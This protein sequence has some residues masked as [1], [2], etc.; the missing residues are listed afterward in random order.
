LSTEDE[1]EQRQH[2]GRPGDDQ[3]RADDQRHPP[4]EVDDQ[5]GRQGDA[6]EGD[7]GADADQLPDHLAGRPLE[8]GEVEPQPGL[9][10]DQPDAERDEGLEGGAEQGFGVDVVGQYPGDEADRQ[11][12][13]QRRDPQ[14]LGD[15]A[16]G[17]GEDDDQAEAG[18]DV[19]G[20]EHGAGQEDGH[21]AR[22]PSR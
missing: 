5:P 9:E 1:G 18:E 16:G 3:D 2:H 6:D 10:E 21:Q 12:D 17:D 14:P 4:A 11:Q 13:H 19:V 8:L 22:S 7:E 15:Q 20:G